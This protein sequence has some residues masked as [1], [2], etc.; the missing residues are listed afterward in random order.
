M[1]QSETALTRVLL[2]TR[3]YQLFCVMA[4]QNWSQ[5]G[6]G[7]KGAQRNVGI[8]AILKSGRMDTEHFA[9]ILGCVDPMEVTHVVE[10]RK[11]RSGATR[12]TCRSL[13][14]GSTRSR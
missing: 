4:H 2:E 5:A 8:E 11:L 12:R 9:K 14:S 1:A 6:E 3:E 7:L 10:T 13:S